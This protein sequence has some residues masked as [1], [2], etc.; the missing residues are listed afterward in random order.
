MPNKKVNSLVYLGADF[1]LCINW[2]NVVNPH[3]SDNTPLMTLP[4]S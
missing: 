1:F 2:L 3:F 4:G